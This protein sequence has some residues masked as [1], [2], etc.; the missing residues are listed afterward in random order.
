MYENKVKSDKIGKHISELR[1]E[2]G[3]TQKSLSEAIFVGEKT[4]SKWERGIIVPDIIMIKI[5]ADLFEVSM[6]ELIGVEMIKVNNKKMSVINIYITF[7]QD[8]K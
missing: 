7:K 3:Y 2:K 4:I 8:S 6:E 5:L 1:K